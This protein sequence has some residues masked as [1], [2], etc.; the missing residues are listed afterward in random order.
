MSGDLEG[1]ACSTI[2]LLRPVVL[3]RAGPLVAAT[4]VQGEVRDDGLRRL[5][6]AL[7]AGREPRDL[8]ASWG[9][10]VKALALVYGGV[11][12]FYVGGEAPVLVS[13]AMPSSP[14]ALEPRGSCRPPELGLE[15]LLREWARLLS[16]EDEALEPL[17]SCT[18]E[19][20]GYGL[21][22]G[23]GEPLP[24]TGVLLEA[25]GPG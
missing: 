18:L 13:R 25:G 22:V 12:L 2:R 24:P 6:C 16:G 15:G 20:R 10:L 19:P 1:L 11:T 9:D 14:V 7:L 17:G 21:R 5:V 23:Y 3:A 4:V 8:D